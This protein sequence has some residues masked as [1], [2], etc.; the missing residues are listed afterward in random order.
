ML[1]AISVGIGKE[2][3]PRMSSEKQYLTRG[4]GLGDIP[5]IVKTLCSCKQL[6]VAAIPK[7]PTGF[8]CGNR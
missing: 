4:L 3:P 2:N 7:G 6:L 5:G 8:A 1:R